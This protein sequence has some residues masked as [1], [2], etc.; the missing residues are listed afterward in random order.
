MKKKSKLVH[1]T[2]MFNT[3]Q[4]HPAV[5]KIKSKLTQALKVLFSLLLP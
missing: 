5:S 2:C 4:W 1:I 3:F